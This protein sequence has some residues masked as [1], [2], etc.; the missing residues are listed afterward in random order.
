MIEEFTTNKHVDAFKQLSHLR[1]INHRDIKQT[2]VRHG[3]RSLTVSLTVAYTHG[4]HLTLYLIGIQT[5]RHFVV[6]TLEQQQ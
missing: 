5:N 3:I 4:H 6:H 1:M 2:I